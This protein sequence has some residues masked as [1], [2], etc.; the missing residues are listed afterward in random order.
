M[1]LRVI[2][3]F[4]LVA[5]LVAVLPVVRAP[6]ITTEADWGQ[7]AINSG[8]G[9]TTNY[10]GLEVLVGTE[11]TAYA[12]TTDPAFQEGED[13][14]VKFRWLYPN[15]SEFIVV[16]G[17]Y[18]GDEVWGDLTIHVFSDTQTPNAVGDWGVQAVFYDAAGKGLGPIPDQ[19]FP[20][21]IRAQSF[22]SVPEVPIGTIAVVVAMFGALGF[23][24]LRR[25]HVSIKKHL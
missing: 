15:G 24:A 16:T 12:G 1:K 13:C 4:V 23:F 19:P 21:K 25:K 3:I 18:L 17:T 9:V 6:I 5:M 14:H 22:F 7:T 2:S 10:H 8:Y 11:V 20:T